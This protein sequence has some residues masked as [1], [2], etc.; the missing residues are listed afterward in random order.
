[1]LTEI[2]LLD[3]QNRELK[4][5]NADEVEHCCKEKDQS[6]KVAPTLTWRNGPT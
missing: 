3:E 4:D 2:R 1:M 6:S 5:L